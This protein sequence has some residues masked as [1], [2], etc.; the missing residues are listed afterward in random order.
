M[1]TW[2]SEKTTVTYFTLNYLI[3]NYLFKCL[4]PGWGTKI[5][6]AVKQL[7]PSTETSLPASFLRVGVFYWFMAVAQNPEEY[8]AHRWCSIK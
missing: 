6:Q 3:K 7:N 4:I 8:L 1:R 2:I 5:P